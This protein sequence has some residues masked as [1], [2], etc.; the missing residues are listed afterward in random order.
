MIIRQRLY[1][2]CQFSLQ[3]CGRKFQV[4]QLVDNV[5]QILLLLIEVVTIILRA[6]Y[7]PVKVNYLI[8]GTSKE[9]HSFKVV[10]SWFAP[11]VFYRIALCTDSSSFS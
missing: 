2:L 9:T 6:N 5:Y 8:A 7:W 3:G 4:V 11:S 10:V 1:K